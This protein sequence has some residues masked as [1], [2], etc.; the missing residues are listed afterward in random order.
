MVCKFA[1]FISSF[2]ITVPGLPSLPSCRRV[3][4]DAVVGIVGSS[5]AVDGFTLLLLLLLLLLFVVGVGGLGRRLLL[6]CLCRCHRCSSSRSQFGLVSL[7]RPP[8]LLLLLSLLM[9]FFAC[10]RRLSCETG[11]GVVALSS[12]EADLV[13]L[14]PTDD[15]IALSSFNSCSFTVTLMLLVVSVL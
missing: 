4:F 9:L 10:W 15:S 8:L 2:P 14:S 12:A 13:T 5:P 7:E 11:D 3:Y 6:L 1:V